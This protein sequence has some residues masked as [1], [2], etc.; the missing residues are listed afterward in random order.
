MKRSLAVLLAAVAVGGCGTSEDVDDASG[1]SSS[2]EWPTE[3]EPEP[4]FDPDDPALSTIP[5]T[6]ASRRALL[7]RVGNRNDF[8]VP[9]HVVA[10]LPDGPL[11]QAVVVRPFPLLLIGD[12]TMRRLNEGQRAINAMYVADFEILNG[13]FWQLWENPSGAIAADLV[14]AAELVGSDEFADIFRDAQALWPGGRIPRDQARRRELV[15]RLPDDKLSALNERYAATQY[16][17]KT[18]LALV[19]GGYIRDHLGQFVVG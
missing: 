1:P 10:G 2:A 4:G 16:R 8:K 13:G 19:L 15:L 17:R 12:P 6:D 5:D 7:E 3:L 9:R 14:P 18:A 11:V